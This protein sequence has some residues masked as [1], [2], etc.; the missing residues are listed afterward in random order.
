MRGLLLSAAI[1]TC[2][3]SAS[4]QRLALWENFPPQLR[5]DVEAHYGTSIITRPLG[6]D[7]AYTGR[8]TNFVRDYGVKV[9]YAAD[10]HWN[11]AF[12]LGFRKWESYGSW[13]ND[14]LMG[15]KLNNTDVTF[16][17][18]KPAITESFQVN[19]VIPTYSR[20]KIFNKS[21]INFGI[22]L[23]LVTTVSD[24][25]V[26]YSKYNAPPDSSYRYISQY[27]YG[28]GIGWNAGVQ[29]GYTYYIFR[30]WGV[31]AE[32]GA[33]YVDVGTQKTNDVND[34]HHTTRYHMTYIPFNFGIRYRFK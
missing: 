19:Y 8:R 21:N 27:N 14:Y 32:V 25:S 33:R 30:R 2:I 13:N 34:A 15:K 7:D 23:G 28:S 26:G 11:L 24:G 6:P 29:I 18:G 1:F 12:D 10:E 3:G 16:Q 31:N 9:V 20:F 5:W 22:T 4:A 17:L